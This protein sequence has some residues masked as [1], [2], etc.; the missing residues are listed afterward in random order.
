M[1]VAVLQLAKE[2]AASLDNLRIEHL[3]LAFSVVTQVLY[4]LLNT[5]IIHGHVPE[6]FPFSV[7]APVEKDKMSGS[8]SFDNYRPISLVTVISKVFESCLTNYLM[9]E[10]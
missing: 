2:K 1:L 7:I 8:S 9:L 4:S 6:S 3:I 5:C 10:N